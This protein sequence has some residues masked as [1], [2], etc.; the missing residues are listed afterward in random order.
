MAE[1]GFYFDYSCPWT[2]LAFTRLCETATRTGSTIVWYP[3]R[4]DR[5]RHD[6][7][8]DAPESRQDP[9]PRKARYQVKDLSDWAIYCSL[10][11]QIPGA[12]PPD[13]EFALSGVVL[14]NDAGLS[15]RYSEAIF[16]AYFAEGHDISQVDVVREIAESVGLVVTTSQLTDAEPAEQVRA[17]EV[18]LM[19]KGGFDSPTMFVGESMFFGNDRMPLV[20]FALGQASGRT[21]VMPGQH[22]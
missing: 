19:R 15:A 7:N 4:G 14:A 2:Y 3:I 22:G 12:W 20:E 17:N 10:T 13:T 1:V 11:I 8:P 21:F 16:R 18:E 6:V 9:E 5:V